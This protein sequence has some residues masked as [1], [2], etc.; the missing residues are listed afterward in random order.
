MAARHFDVERLLYVS[1][2]EIYGEAQTVPMD[3]S[4]P[5]APYNTYAVSK[6]AADRLCYTFNKEH[7]VPVII[8]RIF[9]S[10][11]PRETEPYVVP[12]IIT[13]LAKGPVVRLGNI[14]ARRDLTYVAD[15]SRGLMAAL[16]SDIP[17]GEAVNV[18]SGKACTVEELVHALGET[19][20]VG[21]VQIEIDPRRMRHHDIQLFICDASKLRSAT[22]WEPK[23]SLAEGLKKTVDWFNSHGQRWCWE[24]W[25]EA[26]L[27]YDA[28][29]A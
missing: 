29:G 5:V 24:D 18:G 26:T 7:G 9:N 21:A 3:E 11:G 14:K 10:Y 16:C 8:A 2:T 12:E 19:M 28:A 6:L 23:V 4:H 25:A 27:L 22:G 15:T 17:N 1:T 20:G 13:Q